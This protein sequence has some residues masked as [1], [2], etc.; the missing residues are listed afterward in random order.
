MTAKRDIGTH[1]NTLVNLGVLFVGIAVLAHPRGPMVTR[2]AEWR[3][4]RAVRAE[5]GRS[6]RQL[7]RLE[8]ADPSGDRVLVMF[9]DFQCPAC[10]SA[11]HRLPRLMSEHD[12]RVVYRHL[13]LRRI[14]PAAE[15][16]AR[17]V[18][19]AEGQD[20]LENMRRYLVTTDSWM[21]DPDWR[22]IA[23]GAGLDHDAFAA[24]LDTAAT[25]ARLEE[26]LS[27]ARRLGITATPTFV[28]RRGLQRGLPELER[29][30]QL[31]DG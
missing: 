12:F 27:F 9:T 13:P 6:W 14:H 18:I 20:R 23:E 3:A 28:T 8:A 30:A 21:T 31:L 25:T 16:A 10:R 15:G 19:C 29:L 22:A 7:A 5:V 17:A 4:D 26:D 2:V 11:E 1:L 24:C